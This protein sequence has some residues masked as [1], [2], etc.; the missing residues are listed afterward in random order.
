MNI[1]KSLLLFAPLCASLLMASCNGGG[2]PVVSDKGIITTPTE[3]LFKTT[4]GKQNQTALNR[5]IEDFK[6]IEPNVTVTLDI[7]SGSY[8]DI[9]NNTITG[10]TTG[11]YGDIVMVY[12]DAVADF[13]N[14]GYAFNLEPYMNNE[15]YG[16]TAED[17]EDLIPT[18]MAEGQ[19]YTLEGTYSLPFSKST[20]VVY[21][22]KTRVLG[23]TLEGINNGN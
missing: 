10:F 8:Q 3:I 13:I 15:T 6:K 11:D 22:N 7:V 14:Y 23:L 12:P 4:A 2:E 1:K 19:K 21:Y 9:A 16:L 20:E 18:F 17:K 5:M